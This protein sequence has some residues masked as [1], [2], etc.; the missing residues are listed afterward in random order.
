[1]HLIV[2]PDGTTNIPSPKVRPDPSGA[3]KELLNLKLRHLEIK[4]GTI[5]AEL[6]RLPFNIRGE[7]VSILATYDS[8]RARYNASISS[9]DIGL[10]SD[11]LGTFS[12]GM[13]ASVELEKDRLLVQHVALKSRDSDLQVSGMIQPFRRPKVD[14]NVN[15]EIVATGFASIARFA[16]IR[17][18][19]L[20]VSGAAHYDEST[21]WTFRG[22]VGGR[23]LV[24]AAKGL[25]LKN[26]NFDSE[27]SANSQEVKFTRLAVSALGSKFAGQGILKRY[28]D[29]ELDGVLKGIKIRDVGLFLSREALPWSGTAEGAVHMSA[30]LNRDVENLA[31]HSELQIS[32]AS[33]AIPVSGAVDLSDRWPGGLVE[34]GNSHLNFTH[35]QLS[36]SGILGANLRVVADSAD[37]NELEPVLPFVIS[38]RMTTIPILPRNGSAHFDGTIAGPPGNSR[39]L[40]D[41]ALAHFRAQGQR[42]DQV[43]SHIE[44]SGNGLDFSSLAV[45]AGLLHAS[46]SGHIQLDELGAS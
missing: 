24:S 39:I 35:T 46:G 21:K 17:A 9:S 19:H 42:W 23:D 3:V 41:V 27:I 37:L 12:S 44:L 16:D 4:Q 10:A 30:T 22:K 11:Q 40:G 34:F 18:G 20:T 36:F 26:V 7:D 45:D 1:M 2:R 5:Y 33:G 14:L 28:R 32:P 43:H 29:L 6:R 25:E 31:V 13:N 8:L 38:R 15:G